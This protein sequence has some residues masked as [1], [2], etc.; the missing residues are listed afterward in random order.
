MSKN[1][2]FCMKF[3]TP[4]GYCGDYTELNC[5]NV[6]IQ[7]V[8]LVYLGGVVCFWEVWFVFGVYDTGSGTFMRTQERKV[9]ICKV[10]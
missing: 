5:K 9:L 1:G 4:C 3:H 2:D 6:F 7:Y 8:V 10:L